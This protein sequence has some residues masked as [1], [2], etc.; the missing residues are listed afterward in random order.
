MNKGRCDATGRGND[1][2]SQLSV[3]LRTSRQV[4]R[5]CWSAVA[6]WSNGRTS[7]RFEVRAISKSCRSLLPGGEK[8]FN[9]GSESV[10]CL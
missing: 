7:N 6:P 4:E 3:V 10:T 2:N 1:N 8:R 9:A 5:P